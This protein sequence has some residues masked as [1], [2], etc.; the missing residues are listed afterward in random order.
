[1]DTTLFAGQEDYNRLR[2][3]SYRGA[4]VFVLAFSLVSRASYENVMKKVHFFAVF[5]NLLKNL[6]PPFLLCDHLFRDETDAKWFQIVVML[7]FSKFQFAVV[8]S[9]FSPFQWLPELRHY[10]PGVPIVL[11]GTKLGEL[12]DNETFPF[13]RLLACEIMTLLGCT[14]CLVEYLDTLLVSLVVVRTFVSLLCWDFV[15][16]SFNETGPCGFGISSN[17]LSIFQQ[18]YLFSIHHS[19]AQLIDLQPQLKKLFCFTY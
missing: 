9:F 4:D 3:L 13:N 16:F 11:A 2:P 8:M 17:R 15:S 6:Q 7:W 14:F 10:A 1:M 5:I 19:E 12:C 18:S